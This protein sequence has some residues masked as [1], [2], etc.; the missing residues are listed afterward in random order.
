MLSSAWT[1]LLLYAVK[2][3][4]EIKHDIPIMLEQMYRTAVIVQDVVWYMLTIPGLLL[5]VG[6]LLNIMFPRK[7]KR[8]TTVDSLDNFNSFQ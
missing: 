6:M 5:L 4:W 3:L 2:M 1:V 7:P 8:D